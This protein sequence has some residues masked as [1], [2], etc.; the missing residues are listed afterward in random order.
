MIMKWIKYAVTS[1]FLGAFAQPGLVGA[2]DSPHVQT[3]WYRPQ[4]F[5]WILQEEMPSRRNEPSVAWKEVV[6]EGMSKRLDLDW[7]KMGFGGPWNTL[8]IELAARANEVPFYEASYQPEAEIGLPDLP[9]GSYWLT[10]KTF[11]SKGLK[12]YGRYHLNVLESDVPP[13]QRTVGEVSGLQVRPELP[14]RIRI[15]GWG[16]DAESIRIK[17]ASIDGD[18]LRA[19]SVRPPAEGELVYEI[20]DAIP[21]KVVRAEVEALNHGAVLDRSEIWVGAPGDYPAAL[22]W[23]RGK[24][25]GSLFDF[26]AG[27]T[28]TT[29]LPFSV[30]KK[31]LEKQIEGMK[32][33]GSETVQLWVT[34]GKIEPLEGVRDWSN[35][36][37]Y[38]K[39]LTE[40]QIPFAIGAGS[41]L[42][43]NGP[44]FAWGDLA[45]RDNGEFRI[46][47]GNPVMSPAS[48]IY[49]KRI[50]DFIRA[51]IGRYQDNPFLVGY[52][53][54]NQG[55]DSGIF[56]DHDT[57][58]DY[59]A[60]A[61]S[62]FQ[63]F[64]QTQYRDVEALNARWG[65]KWRS[66]EEVLPPLPEFAKEVNLS[67]AWQ[68]WTRWKLKVYRDISVDL[69]E[70]IV[71]E[72]DPHRPVV[73]YTAKT[74]PIEYQFHDLPVAAWA[75]A[76]GAGE[77]YR[78]ARINSLT[79]NW[80]LWR[81][82]ESHD[83]PPMHLNHMM[84]MWA[85]SL[86]NGGELIRYN[87]VFNTLASRF[88]EVYPS[89]EE[90]QKTL[91]WWSDTAAW[92]KKLSKARTAPPTLGIFLSWADLLYRDRRWRWYAL[93][94]DRAEALVRSQDFLPVK[95]LSEWTPERAWEGLDVLLVPEDARIWDKAFRDR[96][97]AFVSKGGRAVI[98]G[99][100]GQ[101]SPDDPSRP[102][103]WL[104]DLGA[105]NVEVGTSEAQPVSSGEYSTVLYENKRL[106]LEPAVAIQSVPEN[107]DVTSDSRG[108]PM[109]L[110]WAFGK[111]EVRWCLA[112]T[113][114]ESERMVAALLKESG[115]RQEASSSDSRIDAWCLELDGETYVILNRFLGFGKKAEA[116]R[117]R[118]KV[119]LPGFAGEE[120]EYEVVPILPSG[121]DFKMSREQLKANGWETELLPSEMQIYKVTRSKEES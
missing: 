90:L 83:V 109:V 98:W 42:F 13:E 66:W 65:T 1:V 15:K 91:S 72:L 32:S 10:I 50:D 79:R 116:V 12:G 11:G 121:A 75:T 51:M 70:P 49:Q 108:R 53:F 61:R 104:A 64:L 117:I 34:W 94:G 101:F 102:F 4:C 43:G 80:G 120:G 81:Q 8:K 88:L 76:D 63:K 33:R 84:D 59:S 52:H 39:F 111:G 78:M 23:E 35:L 26:I 21:G 107:V 6:G 40:H 77:D 22:E 93:P 110:K 92:R 2:D 114:G 58:M 112:E 37:E 105:G 17:V 44:E 24:S 71:A 60:T 103:S 9:I 87:L 73:H 46:W 19:E 29:G 85:Q 74:G 38:V 99:R 118:T 28:I 36:D 67:P 30:Q 106:S 95:W 115:A 3:G 68:D 47:R 27:E 25:R 54:M 20:P 119:T 97:A 5:Q 56:Q 31:G 86:R 45:L 7:K 55:M 82:T 96:L 100:S 113:P 57:V 48:P 14:N 16:G 18:R 89:N 69:F 62:S 41:I